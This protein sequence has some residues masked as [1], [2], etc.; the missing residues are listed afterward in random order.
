MISESITKNLVDKKILFICHSLNGGGVERV[1]LDLFSTFQSNNI[2]INLSFLRM[3]GELLPQLYGIDYHHIEADSIIKYLFSFL[4]FN[5]HIYNFV[6]AI[7]Q[8]NRLVKH[9]KPDIILTFGLD[10][11]IPM[12]FFLNKKKNFSNFVWIISEGS[13]NPGAIDKL[14]PNGT[15]NKLIKYFIATRYK[16]AD[17]IT[18]VCHGLKNS[19][20]T[21]YQIPLSTINTIYNPRKPDILLKADSKNN[22][23]DT[24]LES[25]FILAVG[26]LAS[27]KGFDNLLIS[28]KEV[29]KKRD[30]NLIILGEGPDRNELQNLAGKLGISMKVHFMGFLDNP[31]YYMKRAKALVVSSV[32]EGFCNVIIEAMTL[33]CPV[34]STACDYGPLELIKDNENG[35][36]VPIN[37][38]KALAERIVLLLDNPDICRR[39][40]TSGKVFSRK[41]MPEL[42]CEE[43]M[44]MFNNVLKK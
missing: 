32:L 30:I 19:L 8:I 26:R 39:F 11:I 24:L 10:T 12:S 20:I 7:N 27:V 35:L 43:Y 31:W 33:G 37:D 25:D 2:K 23:D 34:I 6:L 29:L 42:I 4:K 18:T 13:N 1:I 17:F 21:N 40:S 36:L 44:K 16:K 3:E 38:P 14:S 22:E 28:F 41:F 15:I 9:L 5:K